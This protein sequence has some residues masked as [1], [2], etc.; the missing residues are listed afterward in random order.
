MSNAIDAVAK[1]KS[2]LHEQFAINT[3]TVDESTKLVDLG[4]DSLHL[5]DVMLEIETELNI[6]ITDLSFSPEATLGELGSIV[7]KCLSD[8][9]HG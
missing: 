4:V 8:G 5:V 9:Q 6:T 2:I 3:T 7:S 1:I